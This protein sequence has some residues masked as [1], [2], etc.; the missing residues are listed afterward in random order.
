MKTIIL[1]GGEG[2]RLGELSRKTPKPLIPIGDMPIIKHIIDHYISYQH[3]EFY[4][5]VGYLSGMFH[6]YFHSISIQED[7]VSSTIVKYILDDCTVWIVETGVGTGTF[8]RLRQILPY[9]DADSCFLT[10]GDGLSDVDLNALLQ[11][12]IQSHNLVT[13]SAVHPPERFG[14]IIIGENSSISSFSEKGI[15]HTSWVNGGYMVIETQ[16]AQ[17]YSIQFESFERD[18]LPDLAQKTLLGAYR[19]TGFWQCMDTPSE[20]AYLNRLWSKNMAP[21]LKREAKNVE[22]R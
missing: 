1:A 9:L 22:Y 6:D 17:K 3:N 16:I 20:M 11:S 12:H 8:G 21:W 4:I 5:C 13:L 10:Y 18:V 19:H 15:D 2:T 7:K 14:R